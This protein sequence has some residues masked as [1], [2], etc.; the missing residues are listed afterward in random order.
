ME[1]SDLGETSVTIVTDPNKTET[2]KTVYDGEKPGSRDF[3]PGLVEMIWKNQQL[4][5]LSNKQDDINGWIYWIFGFRFK[6]VFCEVNV[7]CL[8][9]FCLKFSEV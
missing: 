2:V 9:V 7:R 6:T 5:G 3:F 4:D 8:L 1:S